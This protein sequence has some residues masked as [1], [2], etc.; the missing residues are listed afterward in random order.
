MTTFK[1]GAKLQKVQLAMLDTDVQNKLSGY[2]TSL[3]QIATNVKIKGAKGDGVTDDSVAIQAAIDS[4]KNTGGTIYFPAGSYLVNQPLNVTNIRN[5]LIFAGQNSASTIIGNTS[6]IIFDTTGSQKVRFRNLKIVGG[7]SNPSTLGILFA[8]SATNIYA[9]FNQLENVEMDLPSIPSANGGKGTIGIYNFSSEI[10]NGNNITIG[11]DLPIVFTNTNVYSI[12]SPFTTIHAVGTDSISMSEWVID[13]QSTL[14]P[15]TKS[16]CILDN[17]LSISVDAYVLLDGNRAT[18]SD[19]AYIIRNTCNKLNLNGHVENFK[20]LLQIDGNTAL[21][22]YVTD[23]N[24]H[25]TKQVFGQDDQ[26]VLDGTVATTGL[27][28]G[29]I[30]IIPT[31]NDFT[32]N[33]LAQTGVSHI[34]VMNCAIILNQTQGL[35]LPTGKTTSN[36]IRSYEAFPNITLSSTYNGT[37]IHRQD[38]VKHYGVTDVD[39]LTI[40]GSYS[41]GGFTHAFGGAAPTTG[42]WNAGDRIVNNFPSEQGASGSKY[43]ISEWICTVSG[44][45]GTWIPLRCL[46]GN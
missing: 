35:N 30:N 14:K 28:G 36:I 46:T 20:R 17:V 11:A 12:S 44:T 8:R 25:V 42:A 27:Y 37:T 13:G 18:S 43:I 1:N 45:P 41:L 33:A 26:L 10:G 5:S 34:G 4:I 40:N 6:S 2:D 3:A 32:H 38:R 24:I 21:G 29:E 39:S 19:Y 31:S 22:T 16:A 15:K 9:E 7:S 23:L